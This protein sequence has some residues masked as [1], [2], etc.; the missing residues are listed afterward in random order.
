[1]LFSL[2]YTWI[3]Y[4]MLPPSVV[5]MNRLFVERDSK[6]RRIT[7]N[8]GLTFRNS[9]WAHY[10]RTN[11]N[12]NSRYDFIRSTSWTFLILAV[13]AVFLSIPYLYNNAI[14]YNPFTIFYWFAMDGSLYIQLTLSAGL[15]YLLQ[16]L[17]SNLYFKFMSLLLGKP[18]VNRSPSLMRTPLN[19][20]K[21]L[22][23]PSLYALLK[24]TPSDDLVVPL[25]ETNSKPKEPFGDLEFVKLFYKTVYLLRLVT[26][27]T[28]FVSLVSAIESD[29]KRP[30]ARNPQLLETVAK[31][32]SPSLN[33]LAL[34]Y[35]IFSKNSKGTVPP[36]QRWTLKSFST[37][38]LTNHLVQPQGLF[39]S[40]SLNQ[41]RLNCFLSFY[42]ELS[43]LRLSL[44]NQMH[45]IRWNRWLY[46]YSL[47]HRSSL[48]TNLYLNSFKSA[49]NDNPNATTLGVRNLWVPAAMTST[50]DSSKQ[51][52][53]RGLYGSLRGY[54]SSKNLTTTLNPE[55]TF[56][57]ASP[58]Y[59]FSFSETSYS[60]ALSRFYRF[61]STLSN[62]I[63]FK[64][65]PTF[66]TNLLS[67]QNHP[68]LATQTRYRTE[69]VSTLRSLTNRSTLS[70]LSTHPYVLAKTQSS[71][72][73]PNDS[74][75]AYNANSFFSKE[76]IATLYNLSV[77]SSHLLSRHNNQSTLDVRMLAKLEK[78]TTG[79]SL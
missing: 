1:M 5:A 58:F 24:S 37:D 32:R 67:N 54:G 42:P 27:P 79:K 40:P 65:H 73:Q 56:Y 46:S 14:S 44:E 70:V 59:G 71:S 77:N 69:L 55:T 7:S 9:K 57:N 28:P 31:L 60:W 17:I 35:V 52:S 38:K 78:A 33:T 36:S 22:H 16:V 51:N 29:V 6:H 49:F 76:R 25:F 75:L 21:R 64:P 8:L 13:F 11:I 61:N 18:E 47:L 10:A 39:Y 63:S 48:K 26:E 30:T 66:N 45:A 34:D 62:E 3:K 4:K 23:K 19:V 15:F 68:L 53:L 12:T 43:G 72:T 2:I 41:T 50:L 74:Y 20:P